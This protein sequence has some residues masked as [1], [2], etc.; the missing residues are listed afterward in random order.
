MAVEVQKEGQ[1]HWKLAI[2]GLILI[3]AGSASA[4]ET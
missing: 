3:C 4:T 2:A 1:V